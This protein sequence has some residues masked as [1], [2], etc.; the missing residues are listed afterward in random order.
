METYEKPELLV[1][2]TLAELTEGG[3][4]GGVDN[5]VVGS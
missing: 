3:V 2:G 1:L 4:G 5:Q